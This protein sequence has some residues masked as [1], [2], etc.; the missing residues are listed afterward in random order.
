MPKKKKHNQPSKPLSAK[1][2]KPARPL[3]PSRNGTSAP[4]PES[5]QERIAR[6]GSEIRA[7]MLP[8][9]QTTDPDRRLRV[10]LLTMH[11]IAHWDVLQGS[12]VSRFVSDRDL[13]LM[14]FKEAGIEVIGR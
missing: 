12:P 8:G 10:L 11:V 3:K 7:F 14:T 5:P 2:A 9:A 4:E 1:P 13:E 6:V